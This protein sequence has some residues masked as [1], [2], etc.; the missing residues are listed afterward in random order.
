[1]TESWSV[2]PTEIELPLGVRVEFELSWGLIA[3]D[4]NADGR[5]VCLPETL[6]GAG[7]AVSGISEGSYH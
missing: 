7:T 4:F 3:A 2:E 5:V 6:S 1:M